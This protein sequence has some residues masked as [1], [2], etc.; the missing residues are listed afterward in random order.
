MTFGRPD[1]ILVLLGVLTGAATV[2]GGLLA[3]RL[4]NRIHLIL[5][6]SAGAVIGVALFDLLP[7]SMDLGAPAADATAMVGAGFLAYLAATRAVGGGAGRTGHLAAGGLTLHSL[8]DGLAIGLSF[9]V[10]ATAAA[11][12]T[13]AVLA[14]DLCDGINTVH[15]SLAGGAGRTWARRWLTADAVAPLIGILLSRFIAVPRSNLALILAA[16]GGAFLCLGA[17]DLAPASHARHPRAWTTLATLAGG[18]LIWLVVRLA[19][20]GA[21]S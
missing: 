16:F 8:I 6:F 7:E 4:S 19:G 20:L 9:Q 2:A 1:L 3:L 14:H 13:L 17:S 11:V 18:A 21:S 12:V 15:V 10:S 5:G